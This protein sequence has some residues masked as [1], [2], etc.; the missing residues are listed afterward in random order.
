MS[1]EMQ[2]GWIKL[3]GKRAR[4]HASVKSVARSPSCE[5]RRTRTRVCFGRVGRLAKKASAPG[6]KG[7]KRRR[8]RT[9]NRW[10]GS[11]PRRLTCSPS[12]ILRNSQ[13]MRSCGKKSFRCAEAARSRPGLFN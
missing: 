10:R 7:E 9:S 1:A 13:N 6:L 2:A 4:V 8:I 12:M 11:G 3:R 5:E